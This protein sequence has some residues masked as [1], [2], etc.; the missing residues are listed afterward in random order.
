VQEYYC[1]RTFPLFGDFIAKSK[2]VDCKYGCVEGACLEKPANETQTC[3]EQS[4]TICNIDEIC[5]DSWIS[6]SDTSLC[7]SGECLN[8]I[9]PPLNCSNIGGT[10]CLNTE[11]CSIS[12]TNALDSNRC[13]LGN[14]TYD[15]LLDLPEEPGEI[16]SLKQWKN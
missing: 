13:C 12:W 9:E 14:C 4:G 6:A 10:I 2:L 7:C 5:S 3:S 11:N 1:G 15:P 8:Q 16:I